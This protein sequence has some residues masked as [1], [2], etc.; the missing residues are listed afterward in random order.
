MLTQPGQRTATALVIAS[1]ALVAFMTLWPTTQFVATPTF[2]IICGTLG[3]VDFTLNVLLFVP[4]GIALQWALGR[5]RIVAVI[6][7]AT[8]LLVET[9]QWRLIPG[10]DASIG[11]LV[12][13]A[14]GTMVGAWI[15]V[16]GLRWLTATGRAARRYA[17]AF[18]IIACFM[19]WASAW[20]LQPVHPRYRQWVQL[21]PRR[22][23]MDQFQGRLVAVELNDRPLRSNELLAVRQLLD[24]ASRSLSVRVI[25]E[26]PT[27]P[28][29]R[30]AFIVRIANGL[31]ESFSLTQ[32]G[33]TVVFRTHIAASRLRL[34]PIAAGLEGALPISSMHLASS[35][36][37]F[38]IEANSSPRAI[39]IRRDQPDDESS[40]RLR[41]TVGLA[42]ALFFPRDIAI[43]PRWW[44][45]NALWLGVLVLPVSL[46]TFRTAV[47]QKDH[48]AGL[49]WWSLPLVF[50]SLAA[51]PV[52][53]LSALG[54][55]EWIG[56]L[57]GIAAG[58]VLER[59]T[60]VARAHVQPDEI[61][62]S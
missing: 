42:W 32:R 19:V 49:L 56:V 44:M 11:D 30:P 37:D 17:G 45:A 7:I 59:L 23:N 2:C 8:T 6:G 5:W 27:P 18:A 22:P 52:T 46:L 60:A 12:A 28:T 4:L 57:T 25:L 39:V 10:R 34:R 21:T 55:A 16:Y 53:G 24:T 61:A 9:L 43:T 13:N 15:A 36:G 33:E 26:G 31:E 14:L 41:R 38:A 40:V 58:A 54:P 62:P 3:G 48:S 29:T 51:T 35:S 20:L 50:A 1:L 47:R